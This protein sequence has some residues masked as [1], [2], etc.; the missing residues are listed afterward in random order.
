MIRLTLTIALTESGKRQ[1]QD[2]AASCQRERGSGGRPG[3]LFLL[4]AGSTGR[5]SL[6]RGGIS[7]IDGRHETV[8]ARDLLPRWR[9]IA[10][11]GSVLGDGALLTTERQRS[12][13]GL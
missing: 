13:N 5:A 8:C 11:G 4:V 2:L 12:R 9:Y 6:T 7:W 10:R 3:V 1:K